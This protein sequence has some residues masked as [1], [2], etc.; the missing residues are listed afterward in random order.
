MKFEQQ[1]PILHTSPYKI[2]SEDELLAAFREKDR[3][4]VV[5]PSDLEY[6]IDTRYYFSWGESSGNYTYLVFKRSNWDS[7]RG[8]VFRRTTTYMNVGNLCDWCHSYGGS[9][10][11]GMLSVRVNPRLTIGQYLC[12]NLDCLDKLETQ[13]G[14]SGKNFETLAEQVCEK[15]NRFYERT[16]MLPLDAE[17]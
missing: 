7:P 6:P 13:I 10:Q 11:I 16:V 17:D 9:D 5:L 14:T 8:L 1:T 3:K 12:L 4:H 15:I 2:H